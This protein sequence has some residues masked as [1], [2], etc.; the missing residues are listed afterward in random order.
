MDKKRVML[1]TEAAGA[2]VGRYVIDLA[3]GLNK[4]IFEPIVV[5]SPL[6]MDS[7]FAEGLE[8]LSAAGV[9]IITLEMKRSASPLSDIRAVAE[10]SGVIRS[11]KIDILHCNSSKAGAVGRLAG[12]LCGVRRIVYTPHAYVFQDKAMKQSARKMYIAA[13]RLL[14]P[15][16]HVTINVSENEKREALEAGV[17]CYER[18]VVV[19]NGIDMSRMPRSGGIAHIDRRLAGRRIVGSV[20]RMSR[21]KNPLM[22]VRMAKSLSEMKG[23]DDV[24]FLHVGDG[25]LMDEAVSEAKRLNMAERIVFAGYRSDVQA[26]LSYFD[27]F[28]STS[29][30]EGLPYNLLEAMASGVAI[31]ATDVSGNRDVLEPGCGLLVEEGNHEA[32][33]LEVERLL[34]NRSLFE[35]V[36]RRA[37]EVLQERFSLDNMIMKTQNIYLEL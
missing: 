21:Q 27:V 2:G 3:E 37:A 10:L 8:R 6:R 31:V 14:F 35:S 4:D 7:R 9:E 19:E 11:K 17:G 1:L 33:A 13:E 30:Y 16:S 20:S 26:L 34:S 32:M 36:S 12:R 25:E 5:Y 15:L 23:M 22:F 28:V 18:M 24:M 29:S